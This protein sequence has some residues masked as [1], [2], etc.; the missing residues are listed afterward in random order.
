MKT[1]KHRCIL[2]T[3]SKYKRYPIVS[4]MP[5]VYMPT[6]LKKY[7]NVIETCG[8]TRIIYRDTD[9]QHS[10]TWDVCPCTLKTSNTVTIRSEFS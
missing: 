5:C 4:T 10:V 9:Y 2:D 1:F 7:T 3:Y 8:G 6:C